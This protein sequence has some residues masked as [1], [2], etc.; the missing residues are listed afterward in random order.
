MS[1]AYENPYKTIKQ[2]K[3]Q[4]YDNHDALKID[5]PF[6]LLAIGPSGSGKNVAVHNLIRMVNNWDTVCVIAKHLDQPLLKLLKDQCQKAEK[7]YK[8]SIW[9]GSESLADLPDLETF[10]PKLNNIVLID[11][12]ICEDAKALRPVEEYFIRGRHKNV[13]IA[14][15]T[16]DYYGTPKKIRRNASQIIIKKLLNEPD[17]KRIVKEYSLSAPVEKVKDMYESSIEPTSGDKT[18]HWFTLDPMNPD[19]NLQFRKNFGSIPASEW[20]PAKK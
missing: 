16:Q 12:F 14:F 19:E 18:M 1:L 3:K 20:K 11:D 6:R 4:Q 5:L 15:L 8:T 9:R 2:E 10:N 17:L 13:S 7:K